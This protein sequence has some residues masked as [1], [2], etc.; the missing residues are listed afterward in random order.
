MHALIPPTVKT[1]C[2]FCGSREGTNPLFMETAKTVGEAIAKAGIRL[3]FGA[4]GSGLMGAVARSALN[5]EGEVTG[6]VPQF[7]KQREVPV[8]KI[9]DLIIVDSMH[10]RKGLMYDKSDVFVILPGGLGTL[11]ELVEVV[12]WFQLGLHRKPVFLV[13][14]A[15]FW[16][17]WIKV[18]QHMVD[19][20]FVDQDVLE[21]FQMVSSVEELFKTLNIQPE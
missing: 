9:D 21:Y 15:G 12:T 16:Q 6:V 18:V 4:G 19:T 1:I 8:E 11:D 3:V 7:L 20:G 17:P 13:D 5:A 14:V 10:T 2:V